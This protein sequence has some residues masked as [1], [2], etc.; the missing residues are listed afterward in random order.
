MKIK[1]ST[2]LKQLLITILIMQFVGFSTTNVNAQVNNNEIEEKLSCLATLEDN[3]PDNK[4]LVTLKT[5]VSKGLKSYSKE[6]FSEVSC[7]SVKSLTDH[8]AK[9]KKQKLEK[10]VNNS[11]VS[12][13]KT[14]LLL[15]LSEKNKVF[16]RYN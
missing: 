16:K 13:F 8:N 5:E 15:E 1:Y 4:V 2:I 12:D 6:D 11:S 3:F 10:S 14:T 7:V 9:E